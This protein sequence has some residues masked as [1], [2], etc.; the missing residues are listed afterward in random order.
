MYVQL[1]ID[2][3]LFTKFFLANSFYLQP[4]FAKISNAKYFLCTVAIRLHKTDRVASYCTQLLSMHIIQPHSQLVS[5]IC[6]LLGYISQLQPI[7]NCTCSYKPSMNDHTTTVH[8]IVL[9]STQLQ[10]A[11][12]GILQ[13]VQGPKHSRFLQILLEPRMLSHEFQS[14]LAL[15]TLF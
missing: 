10:P 4:W 6:T 15:W 11:N 8:S 9:S 2:C 13:N 3:S 1:V 14:A 7:A 12:Y 5:Y